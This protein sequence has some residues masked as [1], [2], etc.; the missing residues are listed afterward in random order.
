MAKVDLTKYSKTK[1]AYQGAQIIVDSPSQNFK[2][3]DASVRDNQR[4]LHNLQIQ[5]EKLLDRLEE[6]L[7]VPVT[8][9]ILD[10]IFDNYDTLINNTNN[11]GYDIQL[12]KQLYEVY[13]NFFEQAIISMEELENIT[14][15]VSQTYL[16][17]GINIL[18]DNGE[19]HQYILN[20]EARQKFLSDKSIFRVA[21]KKDQ[22]GNRNFT[23]GSRRD[24]MAEDVLFSI[25][26]ILINNPESDITKQLFSS[27]QI[28]T[29]TNLFNRMA[30]QNF[31]SSKQMKNGELKS[32]DATPLPISR[33]LEIARREGMNADAVIDDVILN[34]QNK[35]YLVDNK[36]GL[37]FGDIE[38]INLISPIN[39]FTTA[40]ESLKL[41]QTGYVN[42]D[43]YNIGTI[44]RAQS[45]WGDTRQRDKFLDDYNT[46]KIDKISTYI[47]DNWSYTYFYNENNE[48]GVAYET[49]RDELYDI[50][51][52]A[53]RAIGLEANIV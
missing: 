48:Y 50:G 49:A 13:N 6:T 17:Y 34:L 36:A 39:G 20:Q 4:K 37:F 25:R 5:Y 30:V 46:G 40:R 35:G 27:K 12:I 2:Y 1:I 14:D 28:N 22:N 9:D 32:P 3:K 10:A 51:A 8:Q 38:K 24:L 44:Y 41:F 18:D 42:P 15:D 53:A 21:M 31:Y 11:I 7:G 23:F 19:L 26:N 45:F 43:I 33:I 16:A 47:A 29:Q 52:Q